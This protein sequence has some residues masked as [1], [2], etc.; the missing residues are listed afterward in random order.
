M[1]SASR[2]SQIAGN[3]SSTGARA[4][5][6]WQ[7]PREQQAHPALLLTP[8]PSHRANAWIAWAQPS[9]P[10]PRTPPVP[11]P[12]P[13]L[14]TQ[15]SPGTLEPS[16]PSAVPLL[17]SHKVLLQAPLHGLF[18]HKKEQCPTPVLIQPSLW[19]ETPLTFGDL[20]LW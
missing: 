2:M 13:P 10:D 6:W 4:R 3:T 12:H 1:M 15:A 17:L 20:P 19:V 18:H 9:Q 14:P 7:P 8:L 5:F 11:F 16:Q